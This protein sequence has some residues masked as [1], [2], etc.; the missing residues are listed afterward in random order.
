[1]IRRHLPDDAA[2]RLLAELLA[3]H[4]P[5]GAV[6]YLQGDLGAG[7]STLARAWL[8]ALG[9]TGTVRSP[10]YTLVERYPVDGGEALHL[11]L[12]R[13]GDAGELDFLGLDDIDAALWLI[14]WPERGAAALAPA[15]LEIHLAIDGAGR[16]VELVPDGQG[17]NA[18]LA[19][20]LDDPRLSTLPEP[21]P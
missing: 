17:G 18:W 5:R 7:K 8:R 20:L 11:D 12:Y 15:D 4:Q 1:M 13:I 9:V 14:E 3:A 21:K 6:V 19:A 10:T 2:T 16:S